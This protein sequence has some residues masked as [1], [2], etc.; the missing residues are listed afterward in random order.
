MWVHIVGICG[1]SASGKTTV[2]RL[3]IEELD[4]PWVTLLSLDSFYKVS[5][6]FLVVLVYVLLWEKIVRLNDLLILFVDDTSQ[7]S[8]SIYW[9]KTSGEKFIKSKVNN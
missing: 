6:K 2:A 1:G 9:F 4:V 5:W 8:S 7:S 3:I